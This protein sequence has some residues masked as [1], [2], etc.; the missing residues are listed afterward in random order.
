MWSDWCPYTPVESLLLL[1]LL[2]ET[3]AG[4]D[5]T[6]DPPSACL[7]NTESILETSTVY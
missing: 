7:E 4:D 5:G 2:L 3:V 1:L 6:I